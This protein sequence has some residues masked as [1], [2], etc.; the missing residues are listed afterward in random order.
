MVNVALSIHTALAALR[1]RLA[2]A[3][4]N[5]AVRGAARA[6]RRS[7]AT[8]RIATAAMFGLGDISFATVVDVGAAVRAIGNAG[9]DHALSGGAAHLRNICKQG[10]V[11]ATTSAVVNISRHFGLVAGAR[12]AATVEP[13]EVDGVARDRQGIAVQQRAATEKK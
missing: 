4:C 13:G 12:I 6:Q 8:G 5:T 7:G 3:T 10:A 1:R 2:A 11:V 9:I